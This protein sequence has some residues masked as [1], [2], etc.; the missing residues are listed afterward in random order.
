M[1]VTHPHPLYGGDMYNNVVAAVTD[2][3]AK[4]GY[5][6]LRF[7]FRGVGGSQGQYDHGIGEQHDI[8]AA[9][10]WLARLGTVSI[11]V[12]GYSFGAWVTALGAQGLDTAQQLILIAPPVAFLDFAKVHALPQLALVIVGG[13][14]SIAGVEDIRTAMATWNS[15]ARLRII[16]GADHFFSGKTDLLCREIKAILS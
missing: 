14:D 12:V 1:I 6:T 10:S 11:D 9:L 4:A 5:T 8:R 7:N 15:Q 2:T 3:Y 13:E 16:E